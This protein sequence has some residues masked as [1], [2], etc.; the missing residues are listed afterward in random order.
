VPPVGVTGVTGVVTG[1]VTAVVG[2]EGV[3]AIGGTFAAGVVGTG[4][5]VGTGVVAGGGVAWATVA[6]VTAA[7]FGSLLI[8]AYAA[9]AAPS[10]S[11]AVTP[12]A[13]AHGRQTPE[14]TLPGAPAPHA[15][16]QS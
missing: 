14:P 16:H 12:S 13:I 11:T 15:R 4:A 7:F 10:R 5:G 2:I 8:A 1:G 9:A 3:F 6:V